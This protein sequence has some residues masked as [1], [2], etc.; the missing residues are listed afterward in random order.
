MNK[1]SRTFTYFLEQWKSLSRHTI[2][3]VGSE[4]SSS[5]VSAI[6]DVVVCLSVRP[7]VTSRYCIE[8]NGQIELVLA[9]RILSTYSTLCYKKSWVSA[10]VLPSGTSSQT[11]GLENFAMTSRSHRQQNSPSSSTVEL[12]DDTYTTIDELWLFNTSRST[13]TLS[14]PLLRFVVD[15]L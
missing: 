1:L 14:I 4:S 13:V 5:Y 15:L 9:W 6:Y 11:P 7:P 3:R 2:T 12:V 10:R 8:T